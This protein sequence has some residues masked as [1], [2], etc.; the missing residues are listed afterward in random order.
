MREYNNLLIEPTSKTPQIDFN[1]LT[2]DLILSGRSIPENATELYEPL[3]LW[4]NEYVKKAKPVTNLRLNLEYFNTAS[5]IWLAKIVKSLSRI[6][7][8]ES[9]LLI[10]LYFNIEEYDS[11]ETEDIRDALSPVIDIIHTST[12][13]IGVK[14][15]GT[16]D[17]GDILK[18]SSVL[19]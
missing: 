16:D 19:I 2:G 18:E 4:V 9:V 7:D 1:N 11:M 10:H 17:K 6:K 8:R 5:S 3:F 13:S 14:I 15:Y 12:I